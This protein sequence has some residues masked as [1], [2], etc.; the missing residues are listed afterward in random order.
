MPKPIQIPHDA[1]LRVDPSEWVRRALAY[2]SRYANTDI[3]DDRNYDAA[4]DGLIRAC[5]TYKAGDGN[6]SFRNWLILHVNREMKQ[7]HKKYGAQSRYNQT[8]ARTVRELRQE[9]SGSMRLRQHEAK[10]YTE[11]LLSGLSPIRREAILLRC[12]GASRKTVGEHLHR[13]ANGVGII[14][15]TA[16]KQIRDASGF[17]PD[18][19]TLPFMADKQFTGRKLRFAE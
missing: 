7:K 4:M 2:A 1:P 16:I 6:K 18:T 9:N 17:K 19:R 3:G 5:Q 15:Q 10:E 12:R 11:K 13:T 14:E 8:H